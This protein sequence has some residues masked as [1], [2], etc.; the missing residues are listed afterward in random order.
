MIMLETVQVVYDAIR[1]VKPSLLETALTPATRFDAFHITSI[2]MS[3]IVFEISDYFDT[4]IPGYA[5]M[6]LATVGDA[7]RYIDKLLS[8]KTGKQRALS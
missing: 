4:E 2:E 1:R 5:L 3:M 8:S 6:D 7:S